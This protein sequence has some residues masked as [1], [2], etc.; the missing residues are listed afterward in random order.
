[1]S[2][3]FKGRGRISGLEIHPRPSYQGRG[4]CGNS[5]TLLKKKLIQKFQQGG[6][7]SESSPYMAGVP[8]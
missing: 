5:S 2:F 4:F 6:I 7:I 8:L 3:F 1:M